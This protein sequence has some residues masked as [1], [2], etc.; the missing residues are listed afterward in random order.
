MS[1]IEVGGQTGHP[2]RSDYPG[3]ETGGLTSLGGGHIARGSL[4]RPRTTSIEEIHSL[5]FSDFS[6]LSE[7]LNFSRITSALSNSR[8]SDYSQYY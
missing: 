8:E 7:T 1:Y 5:F 6:R 4:I 2:W 3:I